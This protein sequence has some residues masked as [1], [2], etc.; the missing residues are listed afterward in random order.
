MTAPKRA[1]DAA[2]SGNQ[3]TTSESEEMYLITI[4]M[5]VEDG[6]EG[7][8][9][10][11]QLADALEVSRVSANEMVKKLDSR[12]LVEYVPYKGALLS[13]EGERIARTI[14]RRRRLWSV[15]LSDQLGLTP[16]AADAVACEFE[17]ITPA[18]VA[19]RLSDF[20]GDPRVSPQGK[21][22]PL[23]GDP[24]VADQP[25]TPLPELQA[26]GS[27]EV[28][29][30]N[31]RVAERSFLGDQGVKPGAEITVL[32]VAEDGGCLLEAGK[33]RVHLSNDVAR[34]VGV[35]RLA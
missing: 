19:R 14:L 25:V 13:S 1:A 23:P 7:P 30:I 31:G 17:H 6:Q 9:P 15:F 32:A 10:V 3:D 11:P 20:L 8:V 2:T 24:G 18:D 33:G 34:L 35:V 26:G 5:A 27:A 28:I 4:A 12:G 21:P 16:R 22:I 29:Q